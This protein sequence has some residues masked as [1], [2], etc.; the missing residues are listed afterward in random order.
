MQYC[1]Q[2]VL[3]LPDVLFC[4]NGLAVR[5]GGSRV[6]TGYDRVSM[7][8]TVDWGHVAMIGLLVVPSG[9]DSVLI[10]HGIVM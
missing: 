9:I 4:R 2:H 1:A 3:S 5:A 10:T 6:T 7:S 8:E